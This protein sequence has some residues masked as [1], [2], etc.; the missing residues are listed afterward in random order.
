MPFCPEYNKK[1]VREGFFVLQLTRAR[2]AASVT[3]A[4]WGNQNDHTP[5]LKD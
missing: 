4:R 1:H 5:E 2:M 3:S